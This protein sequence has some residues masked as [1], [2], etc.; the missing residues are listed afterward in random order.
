MVGI[1]LIPLIRTLRR[2][3]QMTHPGSEDVTGSLLNGN[4]DVTQDSQEKQ[5]VCHSFNHIDYFQSET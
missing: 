4:T 3:D 2:G 5:S 1:L